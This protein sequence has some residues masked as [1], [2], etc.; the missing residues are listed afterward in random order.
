VDGQAGTPEP[1]PTTEV[2]VAAQRWFLRFP[3]PLE[4]AYR[5]DHF[6]RWLV[7]RRISLILGTLTYG[8]FGV[9][10][11]WAAPWSLS[12]VLTLRAIGCIAAICT[13]ALT[14][15]HIWRRVGDVVTAATVVIVGTTVAGMEY[16]LVPGEPGFG[17]YA[18]GIAVVLFMGFAV[19]R[20]HFRH[21]AVAGTILLVVSVAAGLSHHPQHSMVQFFVVEAMI[22]AGFVTGM[23]AAFFIDSGSRRNFLNER[24][25]DRERG[26]SDRLLRNIL[27]APVA[28]RLKRGEAIADAFDDV[29]VLFADLVDFTAISRSM[30]PSQVV[31]FLDDL[32]TRFDHLAETHGLEKIKTIGD[33]YMAVSGIPE[34]VADPAVPAAEMAL[35]MLDAMRAVQDGCDFE[36]RLR[37]GIHTGPVVA[38]VLGVH[39]F[40]YDLWGDTVN[41]ASRM[42]SHG[43]PGKIQVSDATYQR[44]RSRFRFEG[45]RQIDVKGKGPMR[46]YLLVGRVETPLSS[47]ILHGPRVTSV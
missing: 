35:A 2:Q 4:T 38:G 27:P 31:A 29:T 17:I 9:V 34:P 28:E 33:A 32:F 3:E 42:E 20:L 19:P 11:P 16:V 24:E 12:Q 47:T 25:L 1:R 23:V 43:E 45:P 15:T 44:L 40:S 21:A 46:T 14:W 18:F 7:T 26:R 41:T 10:D 13:I 22:A 37:I 8:V 30:Q 39:K 36:P 5:D 6:E